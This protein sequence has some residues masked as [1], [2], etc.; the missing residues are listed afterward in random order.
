[1]Y[2]KKRGKK[3]ASA[4][5]PNDP[6]S[7]P[8]PQHHKASIL[9][10]D[11]FD[12]RL[13]DYQLME[14]I[15]KGGYGLVYRGMNV[16]TGMTVAVKRVQLAGVKEAELESI[17]M[18]IKLLEALSHPNIVKYL[19]SVQSADYLCIILEFVENGAL[20]SLLSKFGGVF[21]EPLVAHYIAQVL[22]GLQ[23]LHQQGVIHRDI[24]G[25]NIL[26]TKEGNIKLADFGVATTLTDSRKSDSVVGTPYWMA[27]EIIE[28]SGQ[29]SSACDIWSVGCTV[30]EL[31]TGKPPYF[32]LQQMPALFRIVQDE[33]P[34]L[35]DGISGMLEDFLMVAPLQHT[36][37]HTSPQQA[38]WYGCY[39]C[40]CVADISVLCDRVRVWLLR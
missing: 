36:H 19:D 39:D 34:P 31:L 14:G 24:K 20:S 28:M 18:E 29:Q 33:H 3:K 1:M 9:D 37:R 4:G 25:A 5:D 23:Y 32:D 21:P 17:L 22:M 15:G 8:P 11:D 27:P 2:M 6:N 26:S 38:R 16:T 10:V 30:L 35:P 40:V 13:G 7:P 12:H